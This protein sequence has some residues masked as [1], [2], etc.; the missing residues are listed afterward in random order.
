MWSVVY[1]TPSLST[2][3]PDRFLEVILKL[4]GQNSLD[5]TI[6]VPVGTRNVRGG[7]RGREGGREGGWRGREE[8]ERQGG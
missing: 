2:H 8:K 7:V 1:T 4:R 6:F 5:D 3:I